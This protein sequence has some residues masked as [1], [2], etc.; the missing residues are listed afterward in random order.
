MASKQ[1]EAASHQFNADIF[2]DALIAKEYP[3]YAFALDD[4]DLEKVFKPYDLSANTR[5]RRSRRAGLSAIACGVLA[6]LIASGEPLYANALN[7][8]MRRHLTGLAALLGMIGAY[9]G[10]TG[11]L[12]AASQ[13][14]WLLDR[15]CTEQLRQ[16]HF[17]HLILR[18]PEVVAAR[19][20]P[21][22]QKA[23]ADARRE[24]LQDLV[25]NHLNKREQRLKEML[26]YHSPPPEWLARPSDDSKIDQFDESAKQ[27]FDA[28]RQMRLEH[29]RSYAETKLKGEMKFAL[30][31]PRN[32]E[33]VLSGIGLTSII[34]LVV[35]H[36]VLGV[37]VYADAH[38]HG[39]VW[40]HVAILWAAI[41]GLGA[42]ALEEGLQ[43]ARE[44]ERCENYY[45]VCAGALDLFDSARNDRERYEAMR[46]FERAAADEMRQFLRN[47]AHARFLI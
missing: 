29:Q 35:L 1:D 26:P 5:K 41:I 7:E 39:P 21:T 25:E 4:P 36:I 42:R 43:P 30:I 40:M 11:I 45:A 10:A 17:Q 14:R 3:D 27:I 15:L 6:L 24:A 12:R 16:F 8:D 44:A 33:H 38:A 28:Y 20:D 22:A 19:G 23:Y 13:H 18:L 9:F 37:I 34:V 47:H 32:Q 2:G 46:G 31:T